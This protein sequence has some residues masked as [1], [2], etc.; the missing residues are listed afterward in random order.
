METHIKI[1]GILHIVLGF[2]GLLG[3]VVMLL[4]MA[5]I[6]IIPGFMAGG[7]IGGLGAAGIIGLL[8]LLF[9]GF[10]AVTS[11]LGI[12]GG[13]GLLQGKSWARVLVI[14]LGA[15]MLI[16]MPFGTALGIY[17]LWALLNERSGRYFSRRE[18]DPFS[19]S[20]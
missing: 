10:V 17:T 7:P 5:G 8:G 16:R 6:A 14:I 2:Y 3:P 9:I 18:E 15:L 1:V 19:C 4:A 12:L 20:W 11:L 13:I